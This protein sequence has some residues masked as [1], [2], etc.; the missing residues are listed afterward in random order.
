MAIPF[1]KEPPISNTTQVAAPNRRTS[2]RKFLNFFNIKTIEENENATINEG[3]RSKSFDEESQNKKPFFAPKLRRFTEIFSNK[4]SNFDSKVSS[5]KEDH[6]DTCCSLDRERLESADSGHFSEDRRDGETKWNNDLS[7]AEVEKY[8][9]F[10]DFEEEGIGVMP[11]KKKAKA[12]K[13]VQPKKVF[14]LM[15]HKYI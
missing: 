11:K 13:D 8:A 15:H 7:E 5:S 10:N 14:S 6:S 1:T 9:G 4:V 3:T 12:K 2:L